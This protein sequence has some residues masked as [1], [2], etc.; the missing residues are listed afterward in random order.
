[1]E[2]KK[3]NEHLKDLPTRTIDTKTNTN[4]QVDEC[5]KI[6]NYSSNINQNINLTEFLELNYHDT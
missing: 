4:A 3:K 5:F 1:M 6:K 2:E